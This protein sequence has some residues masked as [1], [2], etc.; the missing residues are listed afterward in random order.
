MLLNF[1]SS[2]LQEV[3]FGIFASLEEVE[4]NLIWEQWEQDQ[5]LIMAQRYMA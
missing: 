4:R 5:H 1:L 2:F 3:H